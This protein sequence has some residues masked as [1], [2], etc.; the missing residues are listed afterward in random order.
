ML[1]LTWTLITKY[2]LGGGLH[3]ADLLEWVADGLK[4]AGLTVREDDSPPLSHA[5]VARLSRLGIQIQLP[6]TRVLASPSLI[7][8]TSIYIVF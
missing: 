6:C 4:E 3:T 2:E 8:H 5:A 7:L 1:G